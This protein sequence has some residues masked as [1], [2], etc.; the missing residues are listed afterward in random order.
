M[1]PLQLDYVNQVTVWGG[2]KGKIR[3][4]TVIISLFCKANTCIIF[5]FAKTFSLHR[6]PSTTF[7]FQ[8]TEILPL[9]TQVTLRFRRTQPLDFNLATCFLGGKKTQTNKQTE[10]KSTFFLVPTFSWI[11]L[12]PYYSQ[13]LCKT[14]FLHS[15]GF[16]G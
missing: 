8:L 12:S 6:H 11:Y 7:S 15:F 5:L 16:L 10:K 13:Q 9:V 3:W 1:L 4:L 14:H 2:K